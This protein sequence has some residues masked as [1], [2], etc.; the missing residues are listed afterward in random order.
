MAK[1]APPDFQTASAAE[2]KNLLDREEFWDVA[3]QLKPDLPREEYERMWEDFQ[4]AK[5]E[6]ER[7]QHL[8]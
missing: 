6:H 2:P 4:K 7:Q 1:T 3:R 5:A 8:Q